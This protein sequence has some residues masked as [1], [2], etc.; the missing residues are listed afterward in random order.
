MFD[1]LRGLS[2]VL[3][4]LFIEQND[5]SDSGGAACG[6]FAIGDPGIRHGYPPVGVPVAGRELDEA[7]G[8]NVL[9]LRAPI[10]AVTS[11]RRDGKASSVAL[12]W[13]YRRVNAAFCVVRL[14]CKLVIWVVRACCWVLLSATSR[15]SMPWTGSVRLVRSL[16]KLLAKPVDEAF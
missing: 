5:E 3:D 4:H 8:L 2:Q 7:D 13:A 1:R 11:S 14:S 15:F 12:T 10:S 6:G 16:L 9:P